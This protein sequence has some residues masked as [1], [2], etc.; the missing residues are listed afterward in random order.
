MFVGI[1][2]QTV[3]SSITKCELNEQLR[4]MKDSQGERFSKR[5]DKIN[6]LKDEVMRMI[7]DQNNKID[8]LFRFIRDTSTPPAQNEKPLKKHE[9]AK[10]MQRV[11]YM[12][13]PKRE[14]FLE[15]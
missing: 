6:A 3:Y 10:R 12:S 13:S 1:V 2:L 8:T 11:L 7:I 4:K 14:D 9:R 15:S 5:N